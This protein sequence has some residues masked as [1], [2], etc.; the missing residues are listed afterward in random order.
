MFHNLT[1]YGAKVGREVVIILNV[2]LQFFL[3]LKIDNVVWNS[4]CVKLAIKNFFT[5][6]PAVL[7]KHLQ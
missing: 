3:Y 2:Y 5:M 1:E 6:L 7:H 4:L